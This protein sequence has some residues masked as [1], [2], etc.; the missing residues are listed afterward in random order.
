MVSIWFKRPILSW[1]L[2]DWANSAFALIVM[3][4]F[5]PVLQAGFWNDGADS[6]VTT[7]RLAM[8]NGLASFVVAITAPAVGAL[9]DRAGRRKRQGRRQG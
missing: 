1:A 6:S 3:T 8:A 9:A 7:F 5:V 2:Y 4:S